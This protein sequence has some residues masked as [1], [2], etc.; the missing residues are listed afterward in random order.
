MKLLEL[1]IQ[2]LFDCWLHKQVPIVQVSDDEFLARVSRCVETE[3]VFFDGDVAE[4][5]THMASAPE[6]RAEIS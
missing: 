6:S 3:Y 2:P 1:L 5:P 4:E